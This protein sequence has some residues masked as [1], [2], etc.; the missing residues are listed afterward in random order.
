MKMMRTCTRKTLAALAALLAMT[1]CGP[2][3]RAA[4]QESAQGK[5]DY[6]P[7][8]YNAYTVCAQTK[9]AQQ[10]VRCLDAFVQQYPGST[11]LVYVYRSYYQSYNELHNNPKLIEYA[12]KELTF[13]DKLDQAVKLEALYLRSVAYY[14]TFNDHDPNAKALATS[15]REAAQQGLKLIAE[16]KPPQGTT[17]EQWAQS[18]KQVLPLFNSVVGLSCT[19]LKDFKCSADGYKAALAD[20][21]ADAVLYFR[22]GVVYLQMDPPQQMD[23]FWALARSVAQKGPTESQ[24]RPYLRKQL[25][26]YQQPGCE[27][28]IDPQMSELLA[29]AAGSPTRPDSYKFPSSAD[30]DAARKDMTIA[31]VL[32]D[33]KAGGDKAK[34]TWLAA[35]GLEFPDVPSKVM[36]VVPGD[37]IVLKVGFVT[38]QEEFDAA[39]TSNMEVKVVGQPEAA[40]IEKNNQARFTGTLV[41]YEPDPLMVHWDK[42]KVNLE[43][44]PEQKKQ[45]AKK[46]PVRRRPP[47]KKPS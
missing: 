32:G 9:D 29:L 7:A 24:V 4:A 23:A 10:R 25:V 43:D 35:C 33:L 11:L 5:T 26:N 40:Q 36:E 20:A 44:I 12:D 31:S 22:L 1:M 18:K 41:S 3:Q 15:A 34:I 13:G 21:P 28:L 37:P 8:E 2:I 46:P 17:E 45:P 14:T 16:M 27:N 42:A 19:A 47:A 30:L 39:T 38:S 6:T